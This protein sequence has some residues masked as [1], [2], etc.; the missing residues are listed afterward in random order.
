VL[1]EE[2]LLRFR[3][4]GDDLGAAQALCELG[5]LESAQGEHELAAKLHQQS[6]AVRQAT[7]DARGIGLSLLSM[8]VAAA[9]AAD[10]ERAW[11]IGQRALALFNRT[12]D[13]PGRAATVMQLGYASAD[14]GRLGEA[15]EL[16]ERSLALWRGFATNTG[17]C[18]P[19]LF[20]LA[21]IDAAL[22]E[23]ERAPERLR[24][25]AAVLATI[26]DREGL[27]YCETEL[28]TITNAGITPQ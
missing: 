23:P 26:G 14:A 7:N 24:Q 17:W 22:G 15:R 27:A 11:E 12:D 5:N 6:L 2:S 19:V 1:L 8:S 4:L 16:L 21:K 20:E 3:R 13:S 10:P 28:R 25:A 9:Y 18:P